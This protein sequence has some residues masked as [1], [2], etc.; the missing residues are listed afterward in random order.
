MPVA[1]PTVNDVLDV[2]YS[3]LNLLTTLD[4][5]EYA[6]HVVDVILPSRRDDDDQ[7][8]AEPET[9]RDKQIVVTIGDMTRNEDFDCPGSPPREG[10]DIEFRIRLRL[11]PSER[12]SESIDKKLVRFI[13]DVRKVLTRIVG[14]DGLYDHNWVKMDDNAID[15]RWESYERLT[16]DG[17]SQSDGYV[18][19]LTVRM[20]LVEGE[21]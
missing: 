20:R 11:M 17:T 18:M 16:N 21:L 7:A 4:A 13:R 14:G 8:E 3:R 9:P 12:D 5:D 6:T 1:E 2:I 10:W 19:P 15:S